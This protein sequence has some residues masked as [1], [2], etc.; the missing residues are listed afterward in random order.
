MAALRGR[1]MRRGGG[2]GRGTMEIW[3]PM[4]PVLPKKRCV[5]ALSPP[6]GATCELSGAKGRSISCRNPRGGL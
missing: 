2:S 5:P 4:P 3:H 1:E 6:M